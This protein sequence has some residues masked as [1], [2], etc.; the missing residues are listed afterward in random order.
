MQRLL[1]LAAVE[2]LGIHRLHEVVNEE[3][4]QAPKEDQA[5]HSQEDEAANEEGVHNLQGRETQRSWHVTAPVCPRS[6]EGAHHALEKRTSGALPGF[7]PRFSSLAGHSLW[8]ARCATNE[9]KNPCKKLLGMLMWSSTALS[10]GKRQEPSPEA[11]L[12]SH[13]P[14]ALIPF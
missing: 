10:T 14:P 3:Q 2:R 9:H 12:P 1:S 7:S 11:V 8:D 13:K 6:L 5:H 4:E